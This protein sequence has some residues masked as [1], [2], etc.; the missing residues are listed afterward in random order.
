MSKS[1]GNVIDPLKLLEKY[2]ADLLR[3]YFVVKIVFLQDGVFSE[4]L[5]KKFYQ[6]FF[7]NNLGNLCARVEKM[8]ELYNNGSVPAFTK[9]ENSYLKEYYQT[10]LLTIN[11]YQ[12][13]M[14]NYQLTAAFQKIQHLLDLSNKLI[15]KLEP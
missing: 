4:E 14:D 11:E 2:T 7:V 12:K 3:A 6:E 5:L 10:L 13:L 8:I 15:Q 9:T 1:K